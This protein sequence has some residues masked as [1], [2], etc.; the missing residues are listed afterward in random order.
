MVD[1]VNDLRNALDV[2]QIDLVA[3]SFG[4]QLALESL[5]RYPTTIG[6]AVLAG[7]QGR[8]DNLLLPSRFDALLKT[9]CGLVAADPLLEKSVPDFEA[10]VR[11][12]MKRVEGIPS[13]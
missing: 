1:D 11:Q 6:R 8:D 4:T 7:V 9:L 13:R 5:R 12:V 3:T 2:P 10:L